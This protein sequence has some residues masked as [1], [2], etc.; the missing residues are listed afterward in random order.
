MSAPRGARVALRIA[1][2]PIALGAMVP[3]AAPGATK[4]ATEGDVFVAGGAPTVREPVGGDLFVAG[5]SVDIDAPVAGDVAAGGGVVWLNADIG[6]A[7]HA[8]A[9]QL[10]VLGKV[11]RDARVAAGQIEF[12]PQSVVA[13]DLAAA[14]GQVRL[15]GTVTGDVHAAGGRLTIDGVVGGEVVAGVGDVELGPH[16]RIGGALR[17]RGGLLRRDPAA[18][19]S[20]GV[21][22]WPGWWGDRIP[23][24][25]AREPPSPAAGWGWTA[26][27]VLLAAA[28]LALLPGFLAR[29]SRALRDHPGWSLGIGLAWLLGAPL[30]LVLLL[31]TVVGI[32]LT[33]LGGLFYVLLMP[34]AY[35][36]AAIA[37]GD[38]ALRVWQPE[39]ATVWG[40]RSAAAALVL[41]GLWQATR[42]PWLGAALVSLAVL[43]GVGALA[44]QLRR[45]PAG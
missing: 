4:A 5:G 30:V 35:V 29:V 3:V 27:L 12:G 28:W 38:A 18:Q 8:G 42:L 40:W 44:L 31:L 24:A 7:L 10:G 23:E 20:G 1:A 21:Q 22:T 9:G 11:G 43:A 17:H 13:G 34:V 41:V 39:A 32:P 26:A 37:I 36:S 16:A 2:L 15:L 19:V 6:G 14:G 25:A 33:L 45:Q